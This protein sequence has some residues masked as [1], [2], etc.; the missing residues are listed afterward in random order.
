MTSHNT[1]GLADLNHPDSVNWVTLVAAVD[2]MICNAAADDAL[3][4]TETVVLVEG[5]HLLA[6]HRGMYS[7]GLA[8]VD[9]IV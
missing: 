6:D 1:E 4:G 9:T 3:H 8:S 5:L 7:R 2:E